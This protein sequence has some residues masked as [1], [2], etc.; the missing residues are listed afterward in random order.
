MLEIRRAKL[1]DLERLCEIETACF[2]ECE[3]ASQ[4]TIKKRVEVINDTFLV[5]EMAGFV[6]GAINA[7]TIEQDFISDDLF[8]SIKANLDVGHRLAILSVACDPAY[9][10]Q[11]VAISLLDAIKKIALATKRNGITLTCKEHLISFYENRG[12]EYMGI[13]KSTHG[14]QIWY[15]MLMKL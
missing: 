4:E 2:L 9:Q 11:G 3:R 8:Q 12:Y 6:V 1:A 7:T 13:A 10:K 15:N 5:A 14:N